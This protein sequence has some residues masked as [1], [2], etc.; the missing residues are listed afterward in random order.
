MHL[1]GGLGSVE[2]LKHQLLVMCQLQERCGIQ[3]LSCMSLFDHRREKLLS[4]SKNIV[5]Q[6]R[7]IMQVIQR[8]PVISLLNTAAVLVAWGL[9]ICRSTSGSR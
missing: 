9:P 8:K 5:E 4:E 2:G 1:E 6:N 3:T 7:G